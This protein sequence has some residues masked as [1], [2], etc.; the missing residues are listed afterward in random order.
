MRRAVRSIVLAVVLASASAS[1][2][3]PALTRDRAAVTLATGGPASVSHPIGNAICRLFNLAEA[4]STAR[5]LAVF[6]EG[7]IANLRH[8]RRGEAVLGLSQSDVVHAAYRGQEPFAAAG[9]DTELR[10]LIALHPE[11]LAVI[12]RADAGIRRFEDLRGKRISVGPGVSSTVARDDLLAAQGWTMSDFARS[13]SLGLAEQ[14]RALCDNRVD[15]ILF[16]AAQPNGFIQEATIGCP[17]RLVPL[18]GP[19]ISRLLAT[20]PYYITA[21]IPGGMYDGNPDDVATFGTQVLL[22][23]SARQPEALAHAV[24]KAVFEN[25]AEFRRLHP[26]L[27]PLKTSDMVPGGVVTPIHPGAARYYRDAGL[28]R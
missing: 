9:P 18:D 21:V 5:C 23:T 13:L 27:F 22:V 15:A 8:V 1:C 16:Q 3:A 24:V 2:V 19:A 11:A 26:A 7:S 6:S 4:R 17:A 25:A 10:T 28:T 20:H 12:A 14:N